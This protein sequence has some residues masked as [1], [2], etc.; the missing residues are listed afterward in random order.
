[1][2]TITYDEATQLGPLYRDWKTFA[3][4]LWF[5]SYVTGYEKRYIKHEG[6][7]SWYIV[8]ANDLLIWLLATQP[9]YT[10]LNENEVLMK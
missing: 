6:W 8:A 1:M 10:I 9:F 5:Y 4:S 2:K 3:V 7:K